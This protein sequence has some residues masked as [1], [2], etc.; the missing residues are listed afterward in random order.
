MRGSNVLTVCSGEQMQ[1]DYIKLNQQVSDTFLLLS[2]A[3]ALSLQAGE[4]SNCDDDARHRAQEE[5]GRE[6]ALAKTS[7]A[8]GSS[9]LACS[10]AVFHMVTDSWF[11]GQCMP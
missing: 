10:H 1:A 5:I 7:G 2:W 3:S 9:C 11:S 4:D 8:T 6:V